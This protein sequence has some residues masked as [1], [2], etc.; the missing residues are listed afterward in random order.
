MKGMVVMTEQ[1]LQALVETIS[2]HFFRRPFCHKVSWNKR[3]RTTGGR[4]HLKTHHID[5]NPR[6][7]DELG[8]EALEGVIKHEL[9]HYHLHL[10]GLGH[11][12]KDA[13]FKKLLKQVGGS[14]FVQ[15]HIDIKQETTYRYTYQCMKCNHIYRRKRKMDT[16]RFC[17]GKCRGKLQLL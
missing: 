1:E 13:D 12:H 9:C 11:Q 8:K 16:N 3:L 10:L 2:I 17:C 5:I 14:R 6:V 7:L 4:Y 15:W